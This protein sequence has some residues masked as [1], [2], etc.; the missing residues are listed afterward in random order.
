LVVGFEIGAH[1]RSICP[2]EFYVNV[3]LFVQP[4]LS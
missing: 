2:D 4:P 1:R 3:F